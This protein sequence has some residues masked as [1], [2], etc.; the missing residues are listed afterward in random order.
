MNTTGS[1]IE[2]FYGPPSPIQKKKK[3]KNNKSAATNSATS[4]PSLSKMEIPDLPFDMEKGAET[5]LVDSIGTHFVAR[6]R[7]QQVEVAS[8]HEF[9]STNH[10]RFEDDGA[11]PR[12][13][14]PDPLPRSEILKEKIS[15]FDKFQAKF[16]RLDANNPK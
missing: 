15:K 4:L 7:A 1:D 16:N 10:S 11:P 14:I 5:I 9:V 12:P 6:A 13:V 8:I 3:K 2:D